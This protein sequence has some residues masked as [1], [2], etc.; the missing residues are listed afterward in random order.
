MALWLRVVDGEV[1]DEVLDEEVT[2]MLC[3]TEI[4][5]V[6]DAVSLLLEEG[7]VDSV[8]L[9]VIVIEELCEEVADRE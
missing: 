3:E 6:D 2:V 5:G 9:A 8:E 4:D 1:L 7:D